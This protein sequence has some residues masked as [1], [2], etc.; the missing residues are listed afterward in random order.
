[1]DRVRPNTD[2]DAN[3]YRSQMDTK[4]NTNTKDHDIN[5]SREF[6]HL[7][8]DTM[9]N[10]YPNKNQFVKKPIALGSVDKR[11]MKRDSAVRQ[12]ILEK[13]DLD[14]IE[15]YELSVDDYKEEK[16]NEDYFRDTKLIDL[17]RVRNKNFENILSETNRK[18]R[19]R[20]K[21]KSFRV[22]QFKGLNYSMDQMK[23]SD[24]LS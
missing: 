13:F 8:D 16:K 12:G 5:E 9:D 3:I 20:S 19:E 1:M 6:D 4:A 21:N 23:Y 17:K 18:I 2:T 10:F 11:F 15:Q 24:F 22:G 7:K 14:E